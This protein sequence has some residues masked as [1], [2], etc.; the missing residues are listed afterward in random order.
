MFVFPTDLRGTDTGGFSFSAPQAVLLLVHRFGRNRGKK[1]AT[2]W[3]I[4]NGWARVSPEVAMTGKNRII[5]Y[6]PKDEGTYVIEFRTSE[7][8]TLAISMPRSETSVIRHF[9]E[10]M[11]YG[12]FVP[13]ES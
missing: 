13:D 12:L 4:D 6:G 10:R 3:A 9:Q 2:T 11:T 5:V 8:E 1:N 7:G